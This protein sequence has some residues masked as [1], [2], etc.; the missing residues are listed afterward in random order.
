VG[1]GCGKVSGG[2]EGRGCRGVTVWGGY[3]E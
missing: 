2:M 1:L 3:D